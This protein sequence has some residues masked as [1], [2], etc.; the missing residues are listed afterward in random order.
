MNFQ[1]I[2]QNTNKFMDNYK[3]RPFLSD[4]HLTFGVGVD[5]TG[6][7]K[8]PPDSGGGIVGL[9]RK[10]WG[11]KFSKISKYGRTNCYFKV[12][13]ITRFYFILFTLVGLASYV[14]L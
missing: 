12:S 4:K 3:Y 8:N 5:R 7:L 9:V 14:R 13:K 2:K 10:V 11:C 1:H 6:S